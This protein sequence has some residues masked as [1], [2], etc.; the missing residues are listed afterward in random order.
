MANNNIIT[1]LSPDM[2]KGLHSLIGEL[3]KQQ[4]V[5]PA[6]KEVILDETIVS[7]TTNDTITKK[8]R[9]RPPKE[10][11]KELRGKKKGPDSGPLLSDE[12]VFRVPL[13]SGKVN[14]RGQPNKFERMEEFYGSK[15]DSKIDK[16]LWGNNR[17][18]KR[19]DPYKPIEAQ[20]TVC[21]KIIK[22]H[23]SFSYRDPDTKELVTTCNRCTKKRG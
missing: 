19:P 12:E 2:L 18:S 3:L 21:G 22:V 16:K 13:T 23:P 6:T 8:K 11:K 15:A 4:G 9:G 14:V 17:P 5:E 20:C 1:E 7:T 10:N